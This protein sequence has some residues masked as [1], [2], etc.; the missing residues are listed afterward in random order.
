MLAWLGE[1]ELEALWP[2]LKLTS[3]TPSTLTS[4]GALE[5]ELAK[6]RRQ[7]FAL[8]DQENELNV[9]CVGAPVFDQ[10]GRVV[11]GMSVSALAFQLPLADARKLAPAVVAAAQQLTLLLSGSSGT[12]RWPDVLNGDIS[13]GADGEL[14]GKAEESRA[15]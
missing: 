7:G 4:R 5:A 2:R 12:V 8:D 1:D 14:R 3:R 13:V 10:S 9:R 11:G 15:R 6:T